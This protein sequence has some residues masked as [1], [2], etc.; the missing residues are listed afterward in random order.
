MAD[1]FTKDD[2]IKLL[3]NKSIYFIGDSNIRALYKDVIQ[4]I[5]HNDLISSMDLKNKLEDS[6]NGDRLTAK[7]EKTNGRT[8][9]EERVYENKSI[10]F[11]A[12]Y[13]F[14]TCCYN[15]YVELIFNRM[16]DDCPNVVVYSSCLW[17]ISRWGPDSIKKHITVFPE[18]VKRLS[19]VL[20]TSNCYFIWLTTLPLSEKIKG[21]FLLKEL[22]FL[23]HG[24]R[25]DVVQANKFTSRIMTDNGFD[26]L[27]LHYYL[28]WHYDKREEDGVHWQAA[29]Y[30]YISNLLLTRIALTWSDSLP[31]NFNSLALKD[32]IKENDSPEVSMCK[33]GNFR[34]PNQEPPPVP[35]HF[36]AEMSQPLTVTTVF[37]PDSHNINDHNKNWQ[38]SFA[39]NK[40]PLLATPNLNASNNLFY[41][42]N[43][44]PQNCLNPNYSTPPSNSGQPAAFPNFSRPPT[45]TDSNG[46]N[47]V[48]DNQY[49]QRDTFNFTANSASPFIFG[50]HTQFPDGIDFSA[51]NAF[52]NI[53]REQFSQSNGNSNYFENTGFCS[54]LNQVS[55]RNRRCNPFI[56]S[57][58]R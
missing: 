20:R 41:G 49:F 2:A 43:F 48:N 53:N 7:G 56:K 19:E 38:Q 26:V 16:R 36:P 1:I 32:L 18:F 28:S 35:T 34:P 4:L 5:V 6:F 9:R 30:R 40:R 13:F 39:E 42:I 11:K 24:L 50:S 44:M 55:R 17:D 14:I 57:N 25:F 21:G 15:E 22:E 54:N 46:K 3:R 8:Y 31:N 45:Y 58:R 27:D 33:T 47:Q 51:P 52:E 37:L 29:A 23:Q 12:R 10:E